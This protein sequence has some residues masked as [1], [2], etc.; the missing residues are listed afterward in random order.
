MGLEGCQQIFGVF[1]LCFSD[2]SGWGHDTFVSQGKG[3]NQ[4]VE[5]HMGDR[6]DLSQ[7]TQNPTKTNNKVATQ[8][9]EQ[10]TTRAKRRHKARDR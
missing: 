3:E 10:E 1:L 4:N 7:K 2:L 8:K 5:T 9:A 6:Q